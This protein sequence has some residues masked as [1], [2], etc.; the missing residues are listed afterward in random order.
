M[1]KLIKWFDWLYLVILFVRFII[2]LSLNVWFK[3]EKFYFFLFY[4]GWYVVE[5]YCI[6]N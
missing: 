4:L 5:F 2:K 3:I 1:F 6:K